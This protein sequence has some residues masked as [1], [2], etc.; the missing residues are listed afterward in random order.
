MGF[1]FRKQ[2]KIF[3]GLKLNISRRGLSSLSAGKKGAT[4][5]V[6]KKG[7]IS[8]TVGIPGTGLSYRT[9]KSTSPWLFI[10]ILLVIFAV[11][12]FTR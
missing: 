7:G 5:N 2:V 4:I 10:G 8:Q 9:D 3:P 6:N 1:R 12:Y 11:W